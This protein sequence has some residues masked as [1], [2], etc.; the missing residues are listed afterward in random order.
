MDANTAMAAK[1]EYL[2][3]VHGVIPEAMPPTAY[4][5]IGRPEL[6]GRKVIKC[7][8]CKEKL[9]DVDKHTLVEI[10]RLSKRKPVNPFPRQIYKTARSRPVELP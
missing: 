10:Y 5:R 2:I 8:Y 1:V 6:A 9:T 4:R 3:V 7:P